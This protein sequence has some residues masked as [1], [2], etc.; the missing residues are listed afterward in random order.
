MTTPSD[1]V[2]LDSY[3]LNGVFALEETRAR[4]TEFFFD[5][6]P[7]DKYVTLRFGM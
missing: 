3:E 6:F 1:H 4:R 5:G 2:N 7:E